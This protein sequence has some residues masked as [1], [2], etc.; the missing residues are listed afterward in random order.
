MKEVRNILASIFWGLLGLSVLVAVLFECE[1]LPSGMWVG[2]TTA[3]FLCRCTM[4][5]VTLAGIWLALRLFKFQKVHAD[6]MARKSEALKKWGVLRLLML[7]VPMLLNTLLYY[8]YMQ[9]TYGYM[10]IIL[11]LCLPFVFPTKGRC[12]DEVEEHPAVQE[13]VAEPVTTKEE[14]AKEEEVSEA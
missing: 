4:E 5:V 3:E 14:A 12:E 9:T 2:Q 7:E 10:A 6:L 8:M 11:L 1:L 13:E